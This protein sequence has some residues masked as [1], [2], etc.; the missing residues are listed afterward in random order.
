MLRSRRGRTVNKKKWTLFA[1]ALILG[2]AGMAGMGEVVSGEVSLIEAPYFATGGP[3]PAIGAPVTNKVVVQQNVGLTPVATIYD[4]WWSNEV[5]LDADGF[6][7]SARLNC[8]PDVSGGTGSLTVYEKIYVRFGSG[9]TWLLLGTTASHTITGTSAYDGWYMDWTGNGECVIDCKIE[10]YRS[11]QSVADYARSDANDADLNDYKMESAAED[12]Q[13][14]PPSPQIVSLACPGCMTNGQWAVIEVRVVNNGG[15]SDNGK[16]VV[17]LPSLTEASDG[18]LVQDNGSSTDSPGFCAYPK[19]AGILHKNGSIITAEC[20]VVELSDADMLNAEENVLRFNVKPKAAGSFPVNVRSGLRLNEAWYAAPTSGALDQQGWWV[21]SRLITVAEAGNPVLAVEPAALTFTPG[22]QVVPDPGIA[23]IP[24]RQSLK[25]M[26]STLRQNRK[27]V[28]TREGVKDNLREERRAVQEAKGRLAARKKQKQDAAKNL[29]AV[30]TGLRT[31]TDRE[32]E[33]FNGMEILRVSQAGDDSTTETSQA[34]APAAIDNSL[35][36]AFPE[37]RSQGYIGSCACFSTVYYYKTYQE[38][39]ERGWNEKNAL[40]DIKFSPA[41]IYN[42]I[43]GGVDEGSHPAVAMEEIVHKGVPTWAAMPY[44][45]R[46]YTDWGGS[47]A[48][49]SAL[50]YRAATSGYISQHSDEGLSLLKQHLVN[51]DCA[52]VCSWVFENWYDWF[53]GDPDNGNGE[54]QGGVDNFVLYENR[55]GYLGAHAMTLVGYDDSRT[56]V[57]ADGQTHAGAFKVANSW[58][59]A[60][61]DNGFFWMSYDFL[62]LTDDNHAG[63][64]Y[65]Y[66]MTDRT[67]YSP[68]AMVQVKVQHPVRSDLRLSIGLGP[69]IPTNWITTVLNRQGGACGMPPDGIWV[70]VSDGMNGRTNIKCRLTINDSPVNSAIGTIM[71]FAADTGGGQNYSP[72]TPVST[73]NDQDVSAGVAADCGNVSSRTITLSNVGSGTLVISGISKRDGKD[74]LSVQAATPV[75][76]QQGQSTSVWVGVDWDRLTAVSGDA[77][78][79]NIYNNTTNSPFAEGVSVMAAENRPPVVSGRQPAE[80]VVYV[81]CGQQM[82]AS[83]VVN[84]PDMNDLC[85]KWALNGT[86][87][88]AAT[89]D[90][91]QFACSSNMIGPNLLRVEVND[92]HGGVASTEWQVVIGEGD[93]RLV[94]Y[95]PVDGDGKDM[96]GWGHNL[97]ITGSVDFYWNGIRGQSLKFSSE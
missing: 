97:V 59:P 5:D 54:G 48:W 73:L 53:D 39:K 91:W 63:P 33:G 56:Y 40:N 10:V 70:D 28:A 31:L 72:D 68:S 51:G 18:V 74:W 6:R 89:S 21:D 92:G 95:W 45:G 65:A 34:A 16:I 66:I 87:Q 79:L 42:L 83:V 17:S 77:D 30:G 25:L 14:N 88:G 22:T 41:F 13:V 1:F 85:Y 93:S 20:L 47:S 46:D 43:N 29:P 86:L 8:D 37:I 38:A 96:S 44:D 55:G 12:A 4:A 69:V 32:I 50:S 36:P 57:G 7:R 19:G 52:I 24:N 82:T 15:R 67:N 2:G 60:F 62:K 9:S 94:G 78:W 76:L 84:D 81:K 64:W 71:E 27:M 3:L 61:A 75:C 23:L 90:S 35:S 49:R 11:G 80:G 58:G 26:A